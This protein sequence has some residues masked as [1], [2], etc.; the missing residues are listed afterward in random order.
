MGYRLL[1]GIDISKDSD[2]AEKLLRK[3]I[4]L[5]DDL[6]RT[7]LGH[8]IILGELGSSDVLKVGSY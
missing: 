7:I 5:D 8:G 3:A 6:A 1:F 4:E 2:R